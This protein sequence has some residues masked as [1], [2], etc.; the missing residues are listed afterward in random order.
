MTSFEIDPRLAAEPVASGVWY[1]TQTGI[2]GR[3]VKPDLALIPAE[4]LASC[5]C[6]TENRAA[7][8]P[9]VLWGY[10]RQRWQ[11]RELVIVDSSEP[12]LDVPQRDDVR[13]IRAPLGMPIGAK[14]NLALDAA[15]GDVIAWFDDDDWQHPE[16]LAWL[17]PLL[18]LEARPLGASYLGPSQS[19][20]VDL[21][22]NQCRKY[23]RPCYAIFNGSIYFKHAVAGE[24]FAEDV[25]RTEDTLWL[26][27]LGRTRLGAALV[28]QPPPVS[29]WLSHDCN[30]SNL[31][32]RRRLAESMDELRLL[33]GPDW[34]DTGEQLAALRERLRA[35][36]ASSPARIA[37][38]DAAKRA[39]ERELRAATP[40]DADRMQDDLHGTVA[41]EFKT[42]EPVAQATID[43]AVA[44]DVPVATVIRMARNGP[45]DRRPGDEVRVPVTFGDAA[46][47]AGPP[48][49][50]VRLYLAVERGE[51]SPTESAFVKLAAGQ[52]RYGGADATISVAQRRM[53]EWI[54][55]DYVG[56]FR[57]RAWAQSQLSLSGLRIALNTSVAR[58]DVYAFGHRSSSSI[59]R[60]MASV[61]PTG[62]SV[63]RSLL[64]DHLR[65]PERILTRPIATMGCRIW[66]AHPGIF[67]RFVKEW[68]IPA[69]AALKESYGDVPE[70]ICI[71]LLECLAPAFFSHLACRMELVE[72]E[73]LPV[74][75]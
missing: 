60:L 1:R 32:S 68:L 33:V 57:S 31:R 13:L 14:R 37:W 9:W 11:K 18:C 59:C 24:R 6:V 12:P 8:L 58:G 67:A 36:P 61:H 49:R 62:E 2:D 44:P 64:G 34:G 56:V 10:D 73:S 26:R 72:P 55:H 4:P 38:I 43:V 15:R 3:F 52:S 22:E 45:F 39:Q 28:G 54:D 71:R 51:P 75:P 63:T 21:W 53:R 17:I 40:V 25:L 74:G 41:V 29:F 70:P 20:F 47:H 65:L 48:I 46:P 5:L 42:T 66:L 30:T 35:E 23:T 19:W 7:F 27:G 69:R 50:R 16:R